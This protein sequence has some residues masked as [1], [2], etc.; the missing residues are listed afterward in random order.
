VQ[1]FISW[2]G[3]TSR[4]VALALKDWLPQVIQVLEPWMSD[5]VKTLAAVRALLPS[6]LAPA[7]SVKLHELK[8][9]VG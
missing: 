4:Q 2:S 3:D 5:P 8:D 7:Q 1:V 6:G 9:Q